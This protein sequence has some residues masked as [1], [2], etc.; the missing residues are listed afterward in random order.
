MSKNPLNATNTGWTPWR[1]KHLEFEFSQESSSTAT[2]TTLRYLCTKPWANRDNF[3][4]WVAK[5]SFPKL[6]CTRSG[7]FSLM[8]I[9][10]FINFNFYNMGWQKLESYQYTIWILVG[11]GRHIDLVR[12]SLRR[13]KNIINRKKKRR[14]GENVDSSC[15]ENETSN[16]NASTLGVSK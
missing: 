2:Q 9:V 10:N 7:V 14:L 4:P 12:W 15:V 13:N 1:W 3:E 8:T 16:C 5:S 11:S 6:F